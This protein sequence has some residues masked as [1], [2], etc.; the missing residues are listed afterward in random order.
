MVNKKYLLL[1]GLCF[2]FAS[3]PVFAQES[4]TQP[5]DGS[6]Q[7][8]GRDMTYRGQNYDVMDSNYV[9][10]YRMDQHRKFMNH[11]Y[12]FPAKPRNMWEIGLGGG[13]YNVIGDVPSLMLWQGGGY[14][15]HFHVRKAWGYVISTRLQ[16]NYG[17]GKGQAWQS[18][19]NY[20][21]NPAWNGAGVASYNY[22]GNA[23]GAPVDQVYYNYKMTSHQI[24]LDLIA[25]TNNIRFHKARTGMSVYGF[26]GLGALMYHTM[27]NAAGPGDQP[28]NFSDIVGNTPQIHENRKAIRDKLKAAMDNTYETEA[29][30]ENGRRYGGKIGSYA[31]KFTPSLGVGMAFRVSKRVNISL[32]DRLSIPWDDDLVDGQRW[33]E[34]VYGSPVQTQNNDM[35][36][37][38]SLGL[39]FNLGNK[40]KNVEPLY[41][42]NPLDYA[43][44]ELNSPRHMLL[45]DP[46]LP[47]ADGDGITDQFDKCPGT[48]AGVAVDSHGCPMDTDGDG[49]PDFR[50]KQLITPTECQ[51]VDADGVGK[52]PCPEGCG[53][54]AP[55]CGNIG[56]GAIN[57]DNNSSRIRPTMQVQLATL[58][59]QMQANPTCKV[60]ITGSGNGSK[61][62]Q[63]RSWDRV[64]AIIEYM[65]EKH[66]IDRNRFIFQ[67]GQPGDA[68]SV[69]YR[70]AMSGEEGPANVAPPF[71]NLRRD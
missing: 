53:T 17:V 35:I 10:K 58:A 25:T 43:Y 8:A 12:F 56:S 20:R 39:N 29:E 64:N 67:Y 1:A 45:P 61:L 21:Y 49:V 60:V 30:T 51:P 24:N 47:D 22:A 2:A 37:Y 5:M 23:T 68:N 26:L 36:N 28:Y 42:L 40:K 15:F 4:Q 52:C 54:A 46:V 59:A 11:Q 33:A 65:S 41:W 62:Q 70:S 9:P 66:G 13:L 55:A 18:S 14:G 16:Y 38:F 31:K 63:Q 32:E 48:P 57:F 50:D 27:I 44:S 34:Q 3:Q 6:A 7:W 69:M 71:P 19:E